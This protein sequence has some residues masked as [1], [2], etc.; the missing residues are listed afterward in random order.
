MRRSTVV[1]SDVCITRH[2]EQWKAMP[3]VGLPVTETDEEQYRERFSMHNSMYNGQ[4]STSH[5]IDVRNE[6][7]LDP[8]SY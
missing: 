1:I 4:R 5:L 3:A 8:I 2:R 6:R 7:I